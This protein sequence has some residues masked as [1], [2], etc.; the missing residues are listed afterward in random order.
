MKTQM[1]I[2]W[3]ISSQ[4]RDELNQLGTYLCDFLR[5]PNKSARYVRNMKQKQ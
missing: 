5:V 2:N 1:W 4:K 3:R